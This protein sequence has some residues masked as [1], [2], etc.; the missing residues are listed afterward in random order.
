MKNE[1][2]CAWNPGLEPDIPPAFQ[3]LET[4]Y[5]PENVTSSLSDVS[6]T[7]TQ[8]GLSHQQLTAFRPERLAVHELLIRVTANIMVVEGEDERDLGRAFR[9]IAEDILA[10]YVQ[11]HMQEI[12]QAHADLRQRAMQWV[13]APLSEALFQTRKPVTKKK[14]LFSFLKSK[15]PD[16]KNGSSDTLQERENRAIL[17]FREMGKNADDELEAAVFKSLYRVLNLIAASRG[18]LGPDQAFLADLVCTH[19]CNN[20]GSRMIGRQISPW[21]EAAIMEKGYARVVNAET[22]VLISLKGPSAAGKS[23]LRLMLRKN[24]QERGIYASSYAT[25]SPDIWRRFLLDY[26]SLGNAYK[27]A[28]RLTSHEVMVIDAK[29]D[30]Y[31]RERSNHDQSLPHLLVDRFR[32]DSFSSEKVGKVLHNTYVQYVDLLHMYFIVTPPELTVDRGWE[33][34]L[35]TGRYKSV[36][37]YLGHS[38]EAYSGMAKM[39]F[40]WLAYDTPRFNFEFLDNDVPKGTY[41]KTIAFGTQGEISILD[42]SAFIAIERYTKINIRAKTPQEVY[43]DTAILS[44]DNNTGFLQQIIDRIHTVNFIDRETKT[45]YLKAQNGNFSIQNRK[46]LDE[47]LEDEET[48][49]LLSATGSL[50]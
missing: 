27:Y 34:G 45:V 9:T 11:P 15:T 21:I 40:K 10:E 38:V 18:Y 24:L 7:S 16:P 44:V 8:T 43:P 3:I 26:D 37:D 30:R 14:N 4:L 32:F 50:N 20:Y 25:I 31:I 36:E 33:R 17:A 19:V 23:S 47:K 22:P 41:P 35:K 13:D 46:I 39:L 49:Q 48:S 28:G 12:K 42:P 5:R 2:Y 29:L 1:R 6:E